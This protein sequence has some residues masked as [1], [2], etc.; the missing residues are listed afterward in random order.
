[1][2]L[3]G[4]GALSRMGFKKA[5]ATAWGT[6]IALVAL[7]GVRYL[8]EG[9]TKEVDYLPDESLMGIAQE[10]IGDPGNIKV[11]GDIDIPCC[12]EGLE[13]MLAQPFGT[14]GAPSVVD[15][16]AKKHVF[17]INNSVEGIYGTLVIDKGV[18][19]HEVTSGKITKITIKGGAGQ[20]T[21]VTFT[22]AGYDLINNSAVNTSGAFASVTY[23]APLEWVLGSQLITRINAQGGGA[24][25]ATDAVYVKDYE[26]TIERPLVTDDYSTKFRGGQIEEPVGDGK[27]MVYGKISFR[28]Y[29]DTNAGGAAPSTLFA[30]KMN[31]TKYKMDWDWLGNTL[32]GAATQKNEWKLYMP[33]VVLIG[34]DTPNVDSSGVISWAGSFKSNNVAAI[35]TGFPA[36]YTDAATM[37]VYSTRAADALV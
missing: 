20:R 10:R 21:I 30:G 27:V 29:T 17:K 31:Q 9:I 19:L 14:A 18:E 33:M 24:L 13:P 16:S 37:E 28:K 22:V 26:I 25:G 2:A 6:A 35:P 8:K 32:I 1:M 11:G 34:P 15:T 3:Y 4:K 36:T 12:Y 7:D 5:T 23:P